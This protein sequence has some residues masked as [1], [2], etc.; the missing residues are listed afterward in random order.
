MI[1]IRKERTQKYGSNYDLC[2]SNRNKYIEGEIKAA[3]LGT[4]TWE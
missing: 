1:N 3:I 2:T 4:L